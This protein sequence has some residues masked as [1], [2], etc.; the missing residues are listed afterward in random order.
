VTWN[1]GSWIRRACVFILVIQAIRAFLY[2]LT[3]SVDDIGP[4]GATYL[5]WAADIGREPFPWVSVGT[6]SSTLLYCIVLSIVKGLF[7]DSI[8][9]AR[10]L[11]LFFYLVILWG[12]FDLVRRIGGDR[13]AWIATASLSLD[14]LFIFIKYVQYEL[15]FTLLT[16]IALRFTLTCLGAAFNVFD[17][18]NGGSKGPQ[19][20]SGDA[21]DHFAFVR[22]SLAAGAAFGLSFL[23]QSKVVFLPA[24][25]LG[26]ALICNRSSGRSR[27]RAVVW[28]A[29]LI[30]LSMALVGGF[31]PWRNYRTTGRFL[32]SSGLASLHLFLGNNPFANG[33]LCYPPEGYKAPPPGLGPDE[34]EAHYR[35]LAIRFVVER[36]FDAICVLVPRKFYHLFELFRP[37]NVLWL[38]LMVAGVGI[39]VR[40]HR[41]W[42]WM[43][44]ATVV[45]YIVMV[46]A[47]LYG[48]GRY[49]FPALPAFHAFVGLALVE[50]RLRVWLPG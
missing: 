27:I 35:R 46:H 4:D 28:V 21:I 9:A 32:L 2:P 3:A 49:R 18:R 36:P 13:M 44:L 15:L 24:C 1:R 41:A 16:L 39:M 26:C 37:R 30:H 31:W 14:D 20:P 22:L 45:F 8:L 7:A 6:A 11:N 48:W 23:T 42:E 43:C 50:L 34:I 17:R 5:R 38:A 47:A 10:V 29:L 40:R 19:D 25:L 33:T 12:T